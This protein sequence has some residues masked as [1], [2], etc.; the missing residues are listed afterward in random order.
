MSPP[1]GRR[2]RRGKIRG[3]KPSP[4]QWLGHECRSTRR[5]KQGAIR[6][7][8]AIENGTIVMHQRSDG[9]IVGK[10]GLKAAFKLSGSGLSHGRKPSLSPGVSWLDFDPYLLHPHTKT[11]PSSMGKETMR[12][13][14]V[15]VAY[16]TMGTCTGCACVDNDRGQ[17]LPVSRA[18]AMLE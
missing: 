4:C 13:S 1:L 9:C 3:L 7:R 5:N 12:D 14:S 8:E 6:D 10:G 15:N 2:R 16:G 17:G 18:E 11:D